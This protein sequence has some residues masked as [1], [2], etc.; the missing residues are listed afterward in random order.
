[1][2]I[3][4]DKCIGCGN[5]IY[6]CP[7]GAIKIQS[8]SR[9]KKAEINYEECVEC[10]L[11][12]R[13]MNRDVK[14]LVLRREICPTKAFYNIDLPY[15][16][17]IRQIFSDPTLVKKETGVFGRGTEEVKTIDVT[18]RISENEIA[19]NI[20]LGR[21]GIGTRLSEI[22]KMTQAVAKV[23]VKFEE[24]NPLTMLMKDKEKGI[25]PEEVLNEKVL[26]AIIEFVITP[27]KV[28]LLLKTVFETK[29]ETVFVVG[30][31]SIRLENGNS[32]GEIYIKKA[33]YEV[34][35]NGKINLGLGRINDEGGVN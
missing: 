23:G 28:P 34:S 14:D 20:E 12:E 32:L 15:P 3:D 9:G 29:V 10:G 11:C 30:S 13:M 22:N 26:S 6:Y 21:P 19:F 2:F 5:C 25:L 8:T 31:Y 24:G 16:R 1:M 4:K 35:A 18:H 17:V 7:V 27:D 33:G